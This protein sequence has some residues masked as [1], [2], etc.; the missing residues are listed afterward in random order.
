MARQRR[1]RVRLVVGAAAISGAMALAQSPGVGSVAFPNSGAAAAQTPFLT[2]LAQLHNF[3][4]DN[5]AELF[6]QAQKIDPDFAMAYWGEAMT[7]T[8]PVWMQQDRDAA[9]KALS[10]L[11]ATPEA[12]A[13]KAKTA[14]EKD[15]LHTVEILYGEGDKF[16]RDVAFAD[17]MGALHDKYPDDP[18]AAA[19]YAVALLGTAHQGRDFAIYAKAASV[20]EPVFKK[21]PN[22]PGAAHY[23]IHSYDDPMHAELGLPAARAYS[24]IAPLAGH[25]QHMTSHI[26]VALGMW[27]D[28]VAANETAITVSDRDRQAKGQGPAKCGHYNMWL[29]YGYLEQGRFTDAKKMVAACYASSSPGPFAGMRAR[30]ILDTEEWTGDVVSWTIPE[31]APAAAR[32]TFEFTNGYAAVRRGDL[33]AA[34]DALRRLGEARQA[35]ES[36]TNTA[37]D[38][39]PAARAKIL[40]LELS[41]LVQSSDPTDT[42]A[43]ARLV[44]ATKIE[45][46][47]PFEFGPPAIDKPP[48]ELLGEVLLAQ[49]HAK[50]ARE[51]FEAALARTPGRTTSLVGLMRAATALGDTTKAAQVRDQLRTIW[52]RA[53][54]MPADVK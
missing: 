47:L 50:E 32:L 35:F 40:E 53:E 26:F 18:E 5:A 15:Y 9:V 29:E 44:E 8:H 13:A 49:G 34:R 12:R 52:K 38:P 46:S 27:D 42:A 30:Y 39:T 36:T 33:P 48:S 41:A 16:A 3:E 43:I 24:K 17:A 20:V 10:R 45:A 11:A 19:F 22:H 54:R 37:T 25:A 31:T 2:G 4:Y 23:L 6:R 14:R 7:Y 51:A 28:V 21:Y 1:W